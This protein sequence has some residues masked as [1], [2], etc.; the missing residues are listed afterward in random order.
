MGW[1]GARPELRCQVVMRWRCMEGGKKGSSVVVVVVVE[2][3]LS[4]GRRQEVR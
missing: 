2:V 1:C 3:G 4:R